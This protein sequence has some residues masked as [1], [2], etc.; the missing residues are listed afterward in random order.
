VRLAEFSDEVFTAIGEAS[1]DVVASAGA[2]DPMAAKVYDSY[3]SFRKKALDWSRYSDQ[4]Y[5]TKRDLLQFT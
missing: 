1:R 4:A 5:M 3:M 2:A